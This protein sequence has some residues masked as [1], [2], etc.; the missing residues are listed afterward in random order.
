VTVLAVS[1]ERVRG[2]RG[3]YIHTRDVV[4]GEM[5]ADAHART[6]SIEER[7]SGLEKLSA[8][9]PCL[10]PGH[11]H[12]LGCTKPRR[13]GYRSSPLALFRASFHLHYAGCACCSTHDTHVYLTLS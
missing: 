3:G 13:P 5:Y 6:T 2:C 8:R 1:L 11:L 9:A 10:T 7:D 4:Q 12:V